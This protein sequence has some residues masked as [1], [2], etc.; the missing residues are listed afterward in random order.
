MSPLAPDATEP[1]SRAWALRLRVQLGRVALFAAASGAGL[2]I[3]F[4]L[5]L[6]LLTGGAT[7]GY[8]NLLSGTAAVS[9][10][11]F[12]SV[13]RIF[14]YRGRFLLGLF[15]AY[16]AYQAAGVRLASWAVAALAMLQVPPLLA[17]LIILP[18]TFPANYLFMSLLA[19]RRE[20]RA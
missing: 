9:F 13:R 4:L 3:D 20:A 11:Y 7:P 18:V 15:A 10:V 1:A 16:L 12:A 6:A 8:A 5:F 2:A 19:A 17:K 14:S